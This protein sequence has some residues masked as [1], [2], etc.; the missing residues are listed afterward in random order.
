MSDMSD[1]ER[2]LAGLETAWHQTVCRL[3]F[4]PC[5]DATVDG[6]DDVAIDVDVDVDVVVEHE[7]GGG[8]AFRHRQILTPDSLSPLVPFFSMLLEHSFWVDV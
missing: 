6:D 5:F 3:P 2:G 1:M 4:L 7:G 8:G